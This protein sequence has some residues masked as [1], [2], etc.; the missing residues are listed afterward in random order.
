MKPVKFE[1]NGKVY[2]L[3]WNANAMFAFF[4]K[5]GDKESVLDHIAGSDSKSWENTVWVLVKLAQQGELWRR[6]NGEDAQKMLTAEDLQRA[7]GVADVL[8]ARNSV[9]E[10]YYAGF[11]RE[12][13]NEEQEV[14]LFLSEWQKKTEPALPDASGLASRRSFWDYLF[15]K[16]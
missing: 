14:D 9:I 12:R 11:D 2:D 6:Y 4:D 16:R 10:A 1:L 5:F 3:L 7:T 8:R 15:G 13:P